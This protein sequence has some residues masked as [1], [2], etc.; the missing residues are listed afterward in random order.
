MGRLFCAWYKRIQDSSHLRWVLT[1]K[2]LLGIRCVSRFYLALK[3]YLQFFLERCFPFRAY[4]PY[5]KNSANLTE[6]KMKIPQKSLGSGQGSIPLIFVSS[7]SKIS[8]SR[9]KMK[10]R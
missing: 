8:C 3:S 7:P 5:S 6:L 4:R 10:E 1:S 9:K 2:G